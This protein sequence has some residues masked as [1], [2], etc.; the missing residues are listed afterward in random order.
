MSTLEWRREQPRVEPPARR[1]DWPL[2]CLLFADSF[3]YAC[4][5]ARDGD[6]AS[7][8][9]CLAAGMMARSIP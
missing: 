2:A 8:V 7:L 4:A 1:F 6:P 3:I 5:F 9:I